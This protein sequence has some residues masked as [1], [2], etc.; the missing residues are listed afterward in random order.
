MELLTS[1]PAG[2][3]A[4]NG[5]L[6]CALPDLP[7]SGQARLTLKVK[8]S[9]VGSLTPMIRARS[10]AL[11]PNGRNHALTAA[12]NVCATVTCAAGAGI[13]YVADASGGGSDP[14]ATAVFALTYDTAGHVAQSSRQDFAGTS[15][16]ENF[17]YDLQTAALVGYA[18]DGGSAAP[19]ARWPGLV[20]I[21]AAGYAYDLYGNLTRKNYALSGLSAGVAVVL[22][23]D[24]RNPFQTASVAEGWFNSGGGGLPTTNPGFVTGNYSYDIAGNVTSDP[25]GRTYSYDPHGRLGTVTRADGGSQVFLRDGLGRILERQATWLASDVLDYGNARS[26][27]NAAADPDQWEVA[28]SGGTTFFSSVGADDVNTR[29]NSLAVTDLLGRSVNT[30]MYGA[31]LGGFGVLAN[32]GYL[33]EGIATN[34]FAATA[35]FPAGIAD[36][37]RYPEGA[38]GTALGIEVGTGLEL[39]GGYRAYDPAVGRFLQWDSM[40]PL[41]RGGLNGYAYAGNDP[42]NFEDPTGHYRENKD[43]RYGPKPPHAHHSGFWQGFG[44]GFK[45]GAKAF[46]TEPYHWAKSYVHDL[47]TGNFFGAYKMEFNLAVDEL[48]QKTLSS[49]ALVP[50]GNL[51]FTE[52]VTTKPSAIFSGHDPFSAQVPAH[53]N[54]YQIG[55]S[56]GGKAGDA[57]SEVGTSVATFLVGA[58]AGA[59]IDAIAGAASAVDAGVAG[60]A[61]AAGATDLSPVRS[62]SGTS[63]FTPRPHPPGYFDEVDEAAGP[64][65][66]VWQDARESLSEDALPARSGSGVAPEEAVNADAQARPGLSTRFK[67]WLERVGNKLKAY[68]E[69]IE[70]KS[71]AGQKV[72]KGLDWTNT[73]FS[74]LS[75]WELNVKKFDGEQRRETEEAGTRTSATAAPSDQQQRSGSPAATPYQ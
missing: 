24:A 31:S 64:K 25:Y 60:D 54:S 50:G 51:I 75:S 72:A 6:S 35:G 52:F 11:D 12:A 30:L 17:T 22:A 5:G 1:I 73:G 39:K 8:P 56:L 42:V 74:K 66:D 7:G 37:S 36:L 27:G 65:E 41:G 69:R 4:A 9:A 29:P 18:N 62:S 71:P 68:K 34:L 67:G 19:Q 16:T 53:S 10:A 32:T 28:L 26:S 63:Y 45:T 13:T 15:L 44:A 2:C 55:Y 59:A 38:M 57:T 46:F 3:A 61:D 14:A 58:A 23:P 70:P 40:S 47:S 20:P 49:W 43:H 21:T 48:I 33:P